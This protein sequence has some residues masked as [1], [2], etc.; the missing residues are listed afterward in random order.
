M[1]KQSTLQELWAIKDATADN[2]STVSAYFEHLRSTQKLQRKSA[3]N[4]V[5]N[6]R[7]VQVTGRRQQIVATH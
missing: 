2:F 1:N 3:N 7:K 6:A 5:S 4:S